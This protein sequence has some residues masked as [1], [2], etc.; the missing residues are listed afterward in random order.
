[1]SSDLSMTS[2][3]DQPLGVKPKSQNGH[4]NGHVSYTNGNH[5]KQIDDGESSLSEDDVPLL[6]GHSGKL[7]CSLR[8]S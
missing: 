8:V 3:D 5:V 6:V 4:S 1:M 7:A 2:D